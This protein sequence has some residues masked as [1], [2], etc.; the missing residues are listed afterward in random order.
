MIRT[1][2]AAGRLV[3]TACSVALVASCA[4][5]RVSSYLE[6][7]ADMGR[8]RTYAWGGTV[9]AFSTGDPRLDN[10]PFFDDRVRTRVDEEL[11]ALGLEKTTPDAADL[12][13]HYH[14][15]VTQRVDVRDVDRQQGYCD[16][17][18]CGP[19]VYDAGTLFVDLVD[20]RTNR[21]V[22]RGW[23]ED[24]LDGVI[25]DQAWLEARIDDAVSRIVRRLRRG[26]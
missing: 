21:L 5:M 17:A 10:S 3:I 8:Y 4:S 1:P 24:S 18:D 12:L 2:G 15:S 14:A 7:G 20:R 11:L 19:Y 22:W 23:A 9:G 6:R 26:A 13:V 25:D 16:E